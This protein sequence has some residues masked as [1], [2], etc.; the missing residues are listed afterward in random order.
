MADDL[1]PNTRTVSGMTQH[2]FTHSTA[3]RQILT[4]WG[5]A[6]ELRLSGASAGAVPLALE[7][8]GGE[9]G[10]CCVAARSIRRGIV[11]TAGVASACS[12]ICSSG[13]AHSERMVLA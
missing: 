2:H 8:C 11:R 12:H 6:A 1:R 10:G 7:P 4:W 13:L 3:L 5:L 9:G